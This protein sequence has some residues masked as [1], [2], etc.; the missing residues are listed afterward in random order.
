MTETCNP[1]VPLEARPDGIPRE[2]DLGFRH[3]PIPT[4]G[5]GQFLTKNLSIA[6]KGS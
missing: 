1:R 2:S 4:V 3:D 5:H 6:L